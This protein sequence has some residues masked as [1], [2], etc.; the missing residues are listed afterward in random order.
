[1]SALVASA[2]QLMKKDIMETL[3]KWFDANTDVVI[4][5]FKEEVKL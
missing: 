4:K 1:M 2:L 5:T 3:P